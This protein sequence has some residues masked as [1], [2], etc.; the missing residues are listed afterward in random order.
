M[1]PK[2]SQ[3][4]RRRHPFGPRK[5]LGQNFLKDTRALD[6]IVEVLGVDSED[7]VIEIGPGHGELTRRILSQKPK[8]LIAIEKDPRLISEFLEGLPESNALE[9]IEGDALTEFPKLVSYKLQTTNYK[10]IG[11]IP[12]YITGYLLRIIGDLENQP[13]LIVLTVQK[14]V[15]ERACAKPPKMNLL[16]ASIGGWGQPEIVRYISK[17]SFKPSPKVDSAIIRITPLETSADREYYRFIK[18]LFSGPRKTILNNLRG[19]GLPKEEIEK[20]LFSVVLEPKARPQDLKVEEIK[21]LSYLFTR[22]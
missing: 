20:K 5:N 6:R 12:Y 2:N 10:L 19:L 21:K 1:D 11:N 7:V 22:N 17:K 9:I 3:I 8:K 13:S 18:T 14:E 16:A 4:R 15:A